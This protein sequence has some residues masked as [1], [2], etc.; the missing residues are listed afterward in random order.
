MSDDGEAEVAL[1]G[2]GSVV[3]FV[4]RSKFQEDRFVRVLAFRAF[5]VVEVRVVV[6]IKE[7]RELVEEE[8]LFAVAVKG[9]KVENEAIPWFAV[10]DGRE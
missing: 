1:F 5:F 3:E 4:L 9:L 6:W 7:R 2:E 8:R 10:R